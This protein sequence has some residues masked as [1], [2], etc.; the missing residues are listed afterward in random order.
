MN[1]RPLLKVMIVILAFSVYLGY[2]NAVFPYL[3]IILHE[4]GHSPSEISIFFA[5]LWI[6]NLVVGLGASIL[7]LITS[8]YAGKQY[9]LTKT[10]TLIFLLF[11][12]I[13][14]WT[15]HLIGYVIRQIE[16][17]QYSILNILF[18]IQILDTFLPPSSFILWSFIGMLAGNYKREL[19]RKRIEP[20]NDSTSP[21][22][23]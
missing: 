5:H 22:T 16:L 8:Y 23:S 13:T 19:D 21:R 12:I 1:L 3:S 20:E 17:P 14:I 18:F 7:I 10:S 15:G 6:V 11:L 4:A 9:K 2:W